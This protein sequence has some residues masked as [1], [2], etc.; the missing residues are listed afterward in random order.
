MPPALSRHADLGLCPV[1][2]SRVVCPPDSYSYYSDKLTPHGFSVICGGQALGGSYPEDTAY[3]VVV[4][5]KFAFLNPKVCDRVLLKLLETSFE[6]APVKQGY[7][8]CS[9]APVGENSVITADRGIYI[10]AEKVGLNALLISNSGVLLP[11]YKNGFFGG[12]CGMISE[13]V[14]AVNGSLS[15]ME[16][17]REI[18]EFLSKLGIS[19]MEIGSGAPFDT[20]SLIPLKI[21]ADN[22]H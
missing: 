22:R 1:G 9:V 12:A 8:K 6:I 3:N 2:G 16:S 19:V 15:Y 17:G 14:L 7:A 5:G 4:A 20:G 21:N 11:P 18:S 10:A 13:K